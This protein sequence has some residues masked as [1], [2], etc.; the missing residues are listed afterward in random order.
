MFTG[1]VVLITGASSGIGA[2][3]A[4]HFAKN[5]AFLSLTGRNQENLQKV[6]SEC[7]K[8][9]KT[10]PFLVIGDL[11]NESDTK[12]ILES[13]VKHYDKLDILINN[14]GILEL[15]SIENTSLDQYDRVFNTNVKSIYHLTMLAVPHLIKTKGNIVNVSSVNGV[16]SFPGLLAYNMSKSAVDQFTKCVALELAS[17]QVRVNSVN[18][19]VILTELQKRGGIDEESYKKFLERSKETHALGRPGNPAEVADAIAFLASEHSS[20]ITGVNLCVDGGR[21]AMCPR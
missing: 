18:P 13:T 9:C 17:K 21:H 1:K 8:V 12:N 16:R 5:G 7:E 4:V 14:A 19:G 11:S 20:F 3:T 15:G 10:K 6:A 2:A